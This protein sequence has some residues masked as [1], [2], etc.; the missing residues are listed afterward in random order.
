MSNSDEI[1]SCF[2][3]TAKGAADVRL[4][5]GR[6]FFSEGP[7]ILNCWGTAGGVGNIRSGGAWGLTMEAGGREGGGRHG[8]RYTGQVKRKKKNETKRKEKR[9]WRNEREREREREEEEEEEEGE[10]EGEEEEEEDQGKSAPQL[11]PGRNRRIEV[12]FQFFLI[13][14]KTQMLKIEWEKQKTKDKK[15][16]HRAYSTAVLNIRIS[17][18]WNF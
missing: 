16:L 12:K 4:F 11:S 6:V 8:Q 2:S 17:L 13:S 10:E 1:Q 15:E 3:M 9:T 7:R 14:V 18:K 5:R